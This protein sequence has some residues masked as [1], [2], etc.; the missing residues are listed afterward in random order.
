M[1]IERLYEDRYQAVSQIKRKQVWAILVDRVFQRWIPREG[2]VLDLGAGSCEFINS[3]RARERWALD[4]SARISENADRE[5][6]CLVG[7][8]ERLR[9]LEEKSFDAVFA[10]NVF[11]HLPSPE[12]LADCLRAVRRLL[13]DGGCLIV[14]GPNIKFG[15]REYWDFA[16]H[17][18]P[19]S[20]QTVLE[21]LVNAG[22]VVVECR[23]RFLPYSFT[24]RLPATGWLVR[25]YLR[26]PLAQRILGKQFLIVAR[27]T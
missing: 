1:D 11:E 16:D 6:R 19:L 8:W 23:P 18:L 7:T 9:E 21:H 3:V 20:H 4:A 2:R 24:G 27:R 22:Y 12:A 5:V 25:L 17:R 15:Y 13:R 14:M 26:L 10:S